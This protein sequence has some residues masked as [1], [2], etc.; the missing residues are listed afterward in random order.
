L[1]EVEAAAGKGM[2]AVGFLS[3]EAASAINP[4]LPPLPQVPG[5]PLACFGL[6][7]ERHQVPW[8]AGENPNIATQLKPNL[9]EQEYAKAVEKVRQLIAA[10]ECY[11]LN[12]TFSLTGTDNFA[13]LPLYRQMLA[14]QRPSFG[15]LL[16]FGRFSI[17]SASPELFFARRGQEIVTRPM[18]GTA[19]RGRF[20]AED[21]EQILRLCRS[22]KEL[23]ENLMIVDLLRNDLGMVA[24]TGSVRVQNLFA[25]ETYPTLHQLTSTVRARLRSDVGLLQLLAALFPCGSITGAPKRRAM[26]HI[27]SLET[28]PRGVYCGAI[29]HVGPEEATFSVAIRTLHMDREAGTSTMGVGSA[30]TWDADH[31]SE[32]AEC[33]TKGQFLSNPP[34]PDLIESLRLENGCYLRLERHLARLAWGAGRLGHPFDPVDAGN[35]LLGHAATVCNTSK[36]RLLLSPKGA[37]SIESRPL[38]DNDSSLLRIAIAAERIDSSDPL[39]YLKTDQRDRFERARL[40]HPDADEVLFCNLQ[41]ELTEGTYHSLVLRLAGQLVTPPLASGVLPGVMREEL[42]ESGE[43]TEM[44]L[45]PEHLY[46]AEEIWLINSVR[47]WRRGVFD[48]NPLDCCHIQ[49]VEGDGDAT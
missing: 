28:S 15:A 35:M 14:A 11:Q 33:L 5:L 49:R 6:F 1:N 47:G 13:A 10:G 39:I 48:D 3:Y 8:E 25:C 30:I 16:D 31:V 4:S 34:Q 29:G 43:I 24:E 32:F 45:M 20:P 9:G 23:A 27:A 18:K 38:P 40:E 36:V 26:E 2:H 17:L 46:A 12:L 19:P 22:P 42:L 37:L 41:G 21:L 7:R 44:I